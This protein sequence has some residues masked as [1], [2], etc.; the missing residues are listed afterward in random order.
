MYKGIDDNKQAVDAI[1][2]QIKSGKLANDKKYAFVS[3]AREDIVEAY[4]VIELLLRNGIPVKI[5]ENETSETTADIMA[6]ENCLLMIV[7]TSKK[8]LY[9]HTALIEQ[10]IRFSKNI[11]KHF[12]D[13]RQMPCLVIDL[14]NNRCKYKDD[15]NEELL[16]TLISSKLTDIDKKLIRA[17]LEGL[18][19]SSEGNLG[20][21]INREIEDID[22]GEMDAIRRQMSFILDYDGHLDN[23]TNLKDIL[24]F[25]GNTIKKI[26][27]QHIDVDIELQ[28]VATI[29]FD[30][31]GKSRYCFEKDDLKAEI[32]CSDSEMYIKKGSLIKENPAK[33]RT[34]NEK[35]K[36]LY[37]RLIK[38]GEITLSQSS[39]KLQVVNNIKELTALEEVHLF[40]TG[41]SDIYCRQLWINIQTGKSY[42]EERNNNDGEI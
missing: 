16:A 31:W 33:E 28:E 23:V 10:Y 22:S 7:L 20:K 8:Y 13:N 26:E 19:G 14:A 42:S 2:S 3:Y 41:S 4:Q 5:N 36:D 37:V 6:S 9:S 15:I 21:L 35:L 25:E 32:V 40:V 30:E 12:D 17:G 24:K 38:N 29:H 27:R 18:Y 34:E 1:L 39:E 11:R